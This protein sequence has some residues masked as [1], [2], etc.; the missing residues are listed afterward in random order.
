MPRTVRPLLLFLA[1]VLVASCTEAPLP[2]G[3]VRTRQGLVSGTTSNIEGVRAW[4]GLPYAAPPVGDMRWKA[5]AAP[6]PWDSV[7]AADAF[8]NRCIQTNPWPDMIWNSPAESEDCLYLNVWAPES[9]EAAPVMLWI[10]GGGYFAGSADENR[11]DGSVLASKGVVLVTVNYRLGV[12]GFLAHP[13]LTAESARGASGN[14]GLLDMI[15]ALGWVRDNIASFGGDPG[16]VTIFGESAGSFAV[17][18]LMSSPLA[19]GLFHRAIGESGGHFGGSALSLSTLGMAETNGAGFAE[20][21]GAAT[22]AELRA[23]EPSDL[24]GSAGPNGPRFGPIIDGYVLP[25]DPETLFETGGQNKVPLLAGWNSAEIKGWQPSAEELRGALRQRFP[26]DYEAAAALYPASD[27][28]ETVRSATDFAGDNFLVYS[29]W[30]WIELHASTGGQPVYRYLFDQVMATPAGPVPD[31]DPGAAHATDI[32][33]VFNT[34]ESTGNPV[35]DADRAVADLMASYWANFARSGDPNGPGLPD[36]PAWTAEGPRH[37]MRLNASASA[38]PESDRAR[39]DFLDGLQG[40]DR[41]E[42]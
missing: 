28:A 32:P 13:E 8:G 31:D 3:T 27:P 42:Q 12:M 4:L 1:L 37:V 11:H 38:E 16:N 15:A 36:W 34:L 22:L 7:R 14:Y 20:S 30:K 21:R 39:F 23:T 5:P 10:H 26:S 25:E 35:S 19:A 18:A 29:T 6:A 17:S 41:M 33:F 40:R 2:D 24:V 9:A